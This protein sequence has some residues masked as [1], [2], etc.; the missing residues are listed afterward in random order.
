MCSA[1]RYC[2]GSP[3]AS[4][5]HNPHA[6]AGDQGAAIV[7]T[8]ML[9][10][11]ELVGILQVQST[12]AYRF[13]KVD[14]EVLVLLANTAA[15]FIQQVMLFA[16]LRRSNERV[17]QELWERK[18]S[19]GVIRRQLLMMENSIDG[20]V[21]LDANW[22]YLYVNDAYAAL[23][24][25]PHPQVLLGKSWHDQYAQAEQ[26]YLQQVVYPLLLTE[27]KWRGELV[28]VRVDGSTFPQELS[29]V[30]LGKR[31]LPVSCVI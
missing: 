27:H 28:G 12:G 19:E 25:Y 6:P 21:L 22:T 30:H 17:E 18:Q 7:C 11:G 26:A 2:G 20:I 1:T 31:S 24:G 10:H 3:T 16:D 8:P 29:I 15:I 14:Q 23:Y 4:G 9:A 13:A 5:T